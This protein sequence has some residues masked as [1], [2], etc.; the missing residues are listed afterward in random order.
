MKFSWKLT[1][2]VSSEKKEIKCGVPQGSILGPLLVLI[3]INDLSDV[4]KCSLPILF[5]DDTN[6][7]IM[8]L[9]YMLLKIH[10]TRNLLISPSG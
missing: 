8:G 2:L 1:L 7:F 10:A 4:C 9:I 6:Y 3:Y 5:A